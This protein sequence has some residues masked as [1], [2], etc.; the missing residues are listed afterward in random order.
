MISAVRITKVDDLKTFAIFDLDYTLTK[1]GT[2]GRFVWKS[3]KSRPYLWG[4]LLVST[5]VFQIQYKLGKLPRGAV[6]KTMMKWSLQRYNRSE[7]ESMAEMFAESEVKTGLRPGAIAALKYHEE[8]GHQIV[9]A[10]AAVDLVVEPI[11]QKLGIADFVATELSW[12][13]ENQLMSEF[14]S[15]NCYGTA[16]LDRV[17]TLLSKMVTNEPYRVVFY[18]DSKADLPVLEFADVGIVVDPSAKFKA[19]AESN[20]LPVQ[21]W[22]ENESGF[23][24]VD[25]I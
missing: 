23:K 17:K 20:K 7:L 25:V 6:K 16:K 24:V 13:G 8:Q 19:Y 12:C 9:L 15:P 10:S 2:W 22:S 18:S 14:A 5:I 21:H 11:A 4:P 3:V 1:R